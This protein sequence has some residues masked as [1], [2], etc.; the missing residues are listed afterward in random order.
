MT[1]T[2]VTTTSN[3]VLSYD[4]VDYRAFYRNE[5][6]AE[7]NHGP[8]AQG[9]TDQNKAKQIVEALNE[10]VLKET[11]AVTFNQAMIKTNQLTGGACSVISLQVAKAAFEILEQLAKQ[12]DLTEEHKGRIFIQRVA[13]TVND[14]HV[15]GKVNNKKNEEA[16][17][18]I[19]TIQQ[20]FNAITVDRTVKVDHIVQEKMKALAIYFG[21]RISESTPEIQVNGNLKLKALVEEQMQTLK[22]G[23]YLIRV[24]DY[25]NNHKLENCGHTIIYIKSLKSELYFDPRLGLYQLFAE[26]QKTNLIYN[27]LLSAQMRFKVDVVSFH[28]LES[29]M[30]S[31]ESSKTFKVLQ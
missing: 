26:C 18:D 3:Q 29:R 17:R 1:N 25:T 31:Q 8:L 13:Q 4:D 22:E 5:F 2:N 27:A 21:F 12:D 6:I 14:I 19:R 23:V 30:S 20:A 7:F 11:A 10:S 9:I 16:R 15:L 24:I 28:K